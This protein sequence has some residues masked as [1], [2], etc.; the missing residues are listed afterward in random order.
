[1]VLQEGAWQPPNLRPVSW[2]SLCLGPLPLSSLGGSCPWGHSLLAS[3]RHVS[4]TQTGFLPEPSILWSALQEYGT[5]LLPAPDSL[6]AFE[7]GIF[8]AESCSSG[9]SSSFPLTVWLPTQKAHVLWVLDL[10]R[11]SRATPSH[12]LSALP[13]LMHPEVASVSLRFYGD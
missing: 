10:P 13:L 5:D 8:P 2:P 6:L 11:W 4:L 7:T 9:W 3:W 12:I 1:M